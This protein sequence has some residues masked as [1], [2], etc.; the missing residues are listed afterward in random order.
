MKI[1]ILEDQ[2]EKYRQIE[3]Q[4][5]GEA[6]DADITWVKNFQTFHRVLEREKFDLIIADLVAPQ[7][8]GIEER[9]L[10]LQIIDAARDH[11]CINC[12]SPMLALTQ[13]LQAADES[14]KDL[15]SKDIAV[16][17]FEPANQLWVEPLREKVRACK[18][19]LRFDFLIICALPKEANGFQEAGY[20]LGPL[21]GVFGL[22]IRGLEING[23]KGAIV[24]APR[25]GLVSCAI[26]TAKAIDYFKPDLV[27]M[28][29]ICAGI[30][31]K[32]DIYDVV[33]PEICH[34]HDSGKWGKNGFEPELYSVQILPEVRLKLNEI[35]Q[36]QE[37]IETATEG[38]KLGRSELPD[39]MEHFAP[40]VLLAPTSSGSSVVADKNFLTSIK[41]QHRKITAF[42][43]EAF[44]VYEAARLSSSHPK[45]FSAKAV[46]DDGGPHKGDQYHRAACVLSAKIVYE[47]IRRGL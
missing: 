11:D 14:Y 10:T 29:G 22:E 9:D 37:F 20:E 32:A 6:S 13:F 44:A 23:R 21:T 27:C 7:F 24:I 41:E 45:F 46:V 17:T 35:I 5:K 36:S 38:I 3:E 43:M 34:Q 33:I 16:V 40:K 18:P 15:N 2:E 31:G 28:S 1:L 25:M 39:S 4:V 42:E 12:R 8:D 26:T 30:E 19:P 47:L